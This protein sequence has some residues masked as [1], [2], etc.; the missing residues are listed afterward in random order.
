M[1]IGDQEA[2][3]SRTIVWFKNLIVVDKE[4]FINLFVKD[5][6][7]LELVISKLGVLALKENRKLSDICSGVW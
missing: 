6:R 5:V 3:D 1:T 4:R 2:N 7:G